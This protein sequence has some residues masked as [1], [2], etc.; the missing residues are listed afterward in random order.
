MHLDRQC[1]RCVVC[2]EY[3]IAS[4]CLVSFYCLVTKACTR[5][6]GAATSQAF[7]RMY[8]LYCPK[9]A[10]LCRTLV[11]CLLFASCC[12]C[13]AKLLTTTDRYGINYCFTMFCS[14]A[15]GC[16]FIKWQVE[17]PSCVPPWPGAASFACHSWQCEHAC[18]RFI[19]DV[20][21]Y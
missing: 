21:I 3:D 2:L 10:T 11:V 12:A 1:C 19:I 17:V 14:D 20:I 15:C 5:R 6:P 7:E 4:L 9:I 8:I 13:S 18:R 16:I